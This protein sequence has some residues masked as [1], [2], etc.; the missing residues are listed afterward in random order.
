MLAFSTLFFKMNLLLNVERKW[1]SQ[2]RSQSEDN[3]N[4]GKE[5]REPGR[6]EDSN[7]RVE[8]FDYELSQT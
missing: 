7:T 5:S 3:I 6:A 8:R 2:E 4:T 1:V